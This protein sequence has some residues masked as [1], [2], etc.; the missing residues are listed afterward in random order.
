[1][2]KVGDKNTDVIGEKQEFLQ[3]VQIIQQHR[4]N[5][6]RK[7]NE[8]LVS[9]YYEI[10]EYLS[11]KIRTGEYGDAIIKKISDEISNDYPTLKGF[12]IRNLYLMIQ[13]YETYVDKQKVRPLVAQLSW[14]NNLLMYPLQ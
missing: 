10:G 13:F 14:T 8:E 9:M 11:K 2:V 7:V 4:Q 3:I 1:M 12:S 6:Y 5:A